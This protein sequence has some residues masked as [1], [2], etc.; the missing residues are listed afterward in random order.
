MTPVYSRVCLI[1]SMQEVRRLVGRLTSV[2]RVESAMGKVLEVSRT[3]IVDG[4][5]AVSDK[6]LE[7]PYSSIVRVSQ[8]G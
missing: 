3:S 5:V 4:V 7:L 1:S 2:D 8:Y 6:V